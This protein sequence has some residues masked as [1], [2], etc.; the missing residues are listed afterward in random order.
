MSNRTAAQSA[1]TQ[2]TQPPRYG[3]AAH[4][5][6]D[7]G[8]TEHINMPYAAKAIAR[9]AQVAMEMAATETAATTRKRLLP[10]EK[11][12]ILQAFRSG[13][14]TR[15]GLADT[16]G[17][18]YATVLNVVNAG[19]KAKPSRPSTIDEIAK[20]RAALAAQMLEL[21]SRRRR[22]ASASN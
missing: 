6:F 16:Y 5:L 10:D 17:V 19:K 1:P 20:A 13:K 21:E 15:Q 4:V 14:T 3:E 12:E 8:S 18:S 2:L 11:E 7:D 22:S 9:K